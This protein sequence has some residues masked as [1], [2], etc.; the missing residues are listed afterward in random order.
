MLLILQMRLNAVFKTALDPAKYSNALDYVA[1]LI[2]ESSPVLPRR[3]AMHLMDNRLAFLCDH[4]VAG[5]PILPGAAMLEMASAAGRTLALD[6][7]ADVMN[8]AVVEAAIPA[9]VLLGATG[10]AQLECS[11]TLASGGLELQA[12]KAAGMS[13]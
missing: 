8:M 11:L 7:T 1:L 9:P 5:R 10:G 12:V 2:S 3:M 13:R 4:V 6:G